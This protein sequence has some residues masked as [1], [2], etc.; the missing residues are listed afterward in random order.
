VSWLAREE[1]VS[2]SAKFKIRSTKDGTE[3]VVRPLTRGMVTVGGAAYAVKGSAVPSRIK[4]CRKS[5]NAPLQ[6]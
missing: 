6:E 2:L 1:L 5:V 4:L 3:P